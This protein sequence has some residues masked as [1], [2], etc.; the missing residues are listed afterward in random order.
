MSGN[1]NIMETLSKMFN[2]NKA[3]IDYLKKNYGNRRLEYTIFTKG[4]KR[5]IVSYKISL[6]DVFTYSYKDGVVTGSIDDV[7]FYKDDKKLL[8]IND[9]WEKE[10]TLNNNVDINFE[11]YKKLIEYD[12]LYNLI[13]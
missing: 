12:G 11:E 4:K 1:K 2:D 10:I 8:L 3:V 9:D 5:E 7:V 13:K 6:E